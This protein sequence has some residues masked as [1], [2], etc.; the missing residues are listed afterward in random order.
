MCFSISKSTWQSMA[1]AC[2]GWNYFLGKTFQ[3]MSR[4]ESCRTVVLNYSATYERYRLSAIFLRQD[5]RA[6]Q[7]LQYVMPRVL[8]RKS[9]TVRYSYSNS[10]EPTRD[11]DTSKLY[12]LRIATRELCIASRPFTGIP[13]VQKAWAFE[14]AHF[15]PPMGPPMPSE[16]ICLS[17]P[18][19]AAGP[20]ICC[21]ML[22]GSILDIWAIWAC[23]CFGSRM[24]PIFFWACIMPGRPLEP[25]MIMRMR[26]YS[27]AMAQ[28]DIESM[29][30]WHL[31]PGCAVQAFSDR[32]WSC[33]E[34]ASCS[35]ISSAMSKQAA[36]HASCVFAA[37]PPWVFLP[38][39]RHEHRL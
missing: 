30:D 36:Q 39:V 5:R 6:N 10:I 8:S 1:C 2:R 25:T 22:G 18:C 9:W 17:R 16:F 20:P 26:L 14:H 29:T 7:V 21:S 35:L 24:L 3:Q 27:S 13:T 31:M 12:C 19:R 11:D 37:L 34:S 28:Q 23:N 15:F 4:R 33:T 32:R 38:S